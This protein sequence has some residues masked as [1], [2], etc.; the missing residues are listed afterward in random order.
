MVEHPDQAV[1]GLG[2]IDRPEISLLHACLHERGRDR[3]YLVQSLAYPLRALPVQLPRVPHVEPRVEGALREG[4]QIGLYEIDYPLPRAA[5]ARSFPELVD[6]LLHGELVAHD[7]VEETLLASKVVVDH[8][9]GRP[10]PPPGATPSDGRVGPFAVGR[11]PPL[12]RSPPGR[13]L[14]LGLL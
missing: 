10:P 4:G 14:P 6:E 13:S 12:Q 1:R 5:G 9:R 11:G 2:G 7:R 3:V 8:R